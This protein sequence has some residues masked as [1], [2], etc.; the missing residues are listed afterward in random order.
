MTITKTSWNK[1]IK[2]LRDVDKIAAESMDFYIQ[3]FGIPVQAEEIED[4]I[5]AAY[6]VSTKYGEAAATL[7]CEMYDTMAELSGLSLPAAEPAATATYG[8]VAKTVRG[9]LKTSANADEL[10]GAVSRLVKRAGAD[11]TLKNA[12][13]DGAE[14]AWVPSGDTC[15]F[16]IALASRGWQR[17]SKDA[18]KGGHAEHIHANCD[19]TYSIRFDGKGGVAGYDPEVYRDMYYGAEGNTPNE[20]INSMRRARYAENKDEINAQKRAAYAERVEREK[21]L[22]SATNGVIIESKDDD[23]AFYGEPVRL[24]AGAKSR[25]YPNVTNPFTGEPLNFVEGSRPEYPHDHLLAGKGTKKPIMKIDD[26]VNNYGGKPEDW[27]HEKAFYEV[28]D[29][30]GDIRQV[31]I[32]WFEAPDCGRHEEFVKLYEGKMYRDEYEK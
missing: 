23:V 18:V 20:R 31:S 9:V 22:S 10:G 12:M 17:A 1:Y 3:N 16:C 19:C 13:R 4:F 7:A 24:G 32:H 15:A 26:L 14:F 25:S 29:E 28:Y 27:K 30:T 2:A 21:G 8:E 11:T 5:F 6:N